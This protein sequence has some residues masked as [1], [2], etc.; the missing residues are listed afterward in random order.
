MVPVMISVIVPTLNAEK[1]L[2]ATLGAL[3][4]AALEALVR[5]VIV[6]DGGSTDM[7]LDIAEDAGCK[8]MRA[9]CGRGTQLAAGA[10]QAKSEWLMFVHAD[11]V[12][13]EGWAGAARAFM[14]RAKQGGR[15][16]A[17]AFAFAL[18]GDGARAR[19][20]E[21]IVA[22]RCIALALPYGDQ[23]LLISRRLYDRL[24]GYRPLPI[25]EDVDIVR[26]IGRA[27]LAMLPARAVTSGAR[28]REAGFAARMACNAACL[29]L[30]YL[31]VPPR[32]IVR[33]Y[34]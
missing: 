34:G 5:E 28:Y 27:R 20:L 3:V 25:M 15:K 22:A 33:L 10:Q 21:R 30:Y 31:K 7:T 24:G 13:E 1:T 19:M 14:Q 6:A 23:G 32:Y 11:T 9:A 26:R 2:A 16:Q 29:S 12:L 17:A 4:P 8:L 18:D